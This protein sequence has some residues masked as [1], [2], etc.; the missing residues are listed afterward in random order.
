VVRRLDPAGFG[1]EIGAMVNDTEALAEMR[2]NALSAARGPLNWEAERWEL[3][4]LY[5]RLL[6]EQ[7]AERPQ[8]RKA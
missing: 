5:D 4:A 1:E 3:V 7:G 6:Q 8:R 2:R